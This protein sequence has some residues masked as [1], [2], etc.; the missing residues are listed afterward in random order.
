VAEVSND[1]LERAAKSGSVALFIAELL[2]QTDWYH[3]WKRR[4]PSA[5]EFNAA[6]DELWE[7]FPEAMAR[8]WL[9]LLKAQPVVVKDAEGLK[10]LGSLLLEG[11]FP[12]IEAWLDRRLAK[13]K[14]WWKGKLGITAQRMGDPDR[15]SVYSEAAR[16]RAKQGL[17]WA[18]VA[19]KLDPKSYEVD[20]RSCIERFRKGVGRSQRVLLRIYGLSTSK[21]RTL[22]S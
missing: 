8:K 13:I 20:S 4:K 17:S 1:P 2:K 5:K 18:Q 16:L 10:E 12:E 22:K 9:P 6:I 7:R 3:D 21:S 15:L 14:G 19:R 11:E